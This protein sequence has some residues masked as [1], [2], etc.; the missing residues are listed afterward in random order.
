[1]FVAYHLFRISHG[2]VVWA[3]VGDQNAVGQI[4]S[5]IVSKIVGR[6]SRFNVLRLV[7]ERVLRVV[8]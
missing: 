8:H 4:L 1:M 3:G 5:A 7:G 6:S 2:W